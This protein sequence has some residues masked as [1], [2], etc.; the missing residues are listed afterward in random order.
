MQHS[1][2]NKL[3]N[4]E[5]PL[6]DGSS[7]KTRITLSLLSVCGDSIL[8]YST[9]GL[10]GNLWRKNQWHKM[11]KRNNKNWT[12]KLCIKFGFENTFYVDDIVFRFLHCCNIDYFFWEWN[13]RFVSK[14][15]SI[16]SKYQSISLRQM[17]I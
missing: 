16:L 4:L 5:L 7:P 14:L 11:A 15:S 3:F 2:E 1:K 8:T 12:W 9:F 10:W 13:K 6:V 17:C